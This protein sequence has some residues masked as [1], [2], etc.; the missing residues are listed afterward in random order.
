MSQQEQ[1]LLSIFDN[2]QEAIFVVNITPQGNFRYQGLNPAARRLT[3]IKTVINKTP[4]EILPL[5]VAKVVEEHY[6]QCVESKTAISYEECLP[7]GGKD[8]WW[9]TTLNPIEDQSGRIIR[10]IG[11]SLNI[12][13]R[14]RMEKELNE[15]KAFL[16]ALLD[17]LTDGVVACDRYG[18]LAM[19]NKA[20]QNFFVI[21]Q[22][23]LPPEEWAEH[24]G[25]Y[26]VD[27]KDYLS[28]AEIPLFR[29]FSGESFVDAELMAIPP[30]GQ[31]RI[32]STNGSPIVDEQV[33]KLGA[34]AT[35]QD[36]T[37]RKK[38]EQ[39]IVKLN[40]EL[41]SKVR[42]RTAQ[43]EQVNS[44]LLATTATLEKRNQELDQFAYIT[45]HDLKAPLRAIS[46]LSLWIEE[47]LEDRLDDDTRHKMNLLRGRVQRLE[48]LING[49][50]VYSRVGRQEYEPQEVSVEKML[51]DI[52]DLLDI[53][54]N[55]EVA[56][57]GQMPTFITQAIPL[58]QT[59]NNLIS[60]AIKHSNSQ[61]GMVTITVKE[62]RDFYEF[63]V[64]DNGKGINPKHHQRIF[65]IF[66]T[67]D[68]KDNME[69]T[70][71]GLSIVQKAVENQGGTIKVES[72][73]GL[74]TTF[75]FTWKK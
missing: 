11:T 55:F 3:G 18:I 66:Q 41:E 63:S 47:D 2:V 31:P 61:Q 39:E 26:D 44:I 58:Q 30:N 32:L 38:A 40:A 42:R 19:F 5:D 48:N 14:K 24:Y 70:G 69:N 64:A 22:E 17:N 37:K 36:I 12:N 49:L 29:A 13:E 33:V 59:F 51:A 43:L 20:S 68:A 28:Q 56:I 74:G 21:P 75:R 7:F 9:L 16:K 27:G 60:N 54:P 53:P 71:I 67:L 65:T 72:Q 62:S 23:P 25:L 57:Q 10:I 50:L 52:I 34:V 15:E 8:T 35:I 45:S 1:F 73:P 4:A 6:R 46:N